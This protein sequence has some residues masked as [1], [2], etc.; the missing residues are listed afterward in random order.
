MNA[1]VPSEWHPDT[2]LGESTVD[3][4]SVESA[5]QS[6]IVLRQAVEGPLCCSL[7]DARFPADCTPGVPLRSQGRNPGTVH[8]DSRPSERLAFCSRIPNTGTDSLG[9]QAAFQ[10]SDSP[11]HREHHLAGG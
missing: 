8:G 1:P 2:D 10:F 11:K 4:A 5:S 9:N 7:G 6:S 3:F